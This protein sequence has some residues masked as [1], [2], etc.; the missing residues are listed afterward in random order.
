M[1]HNKSQTISGRKKTFLKHVHLTSTVRLQV[2]SPLL[3]ERAI[4]T[5]VTQFSPVI[6]LTALSSFMF[7]MYSECL[8]FFFNGNA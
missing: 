2:S 7:L 1:T 4:L 5:T 3:Y 6:V 8:F